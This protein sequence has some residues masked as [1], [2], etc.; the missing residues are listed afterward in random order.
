MQVTQL[1]LVTYTSPDE[2]QYDIPTAV[3]TAIEGIPGVISASLY[4][5]ADGT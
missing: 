5:P 1:F 3:A 2:P 4:T